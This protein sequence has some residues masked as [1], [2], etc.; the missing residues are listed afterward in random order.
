MWREDPLSMLQPLSTSK[1]NKRNQGMER[2]KKYEERIWH[3]KSKAQRLRVSGQIKNRNIEGKR[4]ENESENWYKAQ[5]VS[6]W[7]WKCHNAPLQKENQG[8]GK[9]VR[10]ILKECDRAGEKWHP[11]MC[12]WNSLWAGHGKIVTTSSPHLEKF[13]RR[14][15]SPS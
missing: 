7:S 14:S 12:Y 2:K 11:D 15:V 10:E 6:E 13:Y 1:I 5:T 4:K 3:H 9:A 8:N